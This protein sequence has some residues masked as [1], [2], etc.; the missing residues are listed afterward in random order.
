LYQKGKKL[1]EILLD[2]QIISKT[3]ANLEDSQMELMNIMVELSATADTSIKVVDVETAESR[4][5]QWQKQE[6][7]CEK[8]RITSE[9]Y[10]LLHLMSL[11]QVY[12]D[13]I[14]IGEELKKNPESGIKNV[15]TWV[16]A[17]MRDKLKLNSKAE[18]RNRLGCNRLR[19]LFE[20]GITCAQ[21]AQAGLRKCDFFTKA[22]NYEIFYHKYPQWIRVIQFQAH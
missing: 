7:E 9:S 12:E 2:S 20:E 19:K 21:L 1:R 16:I 17:F 10:N 8:L 6:L 15:G 14:R 11:V 13:L 3:L 5:L 18:Q 22:E 4:V